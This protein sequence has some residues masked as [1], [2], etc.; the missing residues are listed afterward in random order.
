MIYR[1][2]ITKQAQEDIANHKKSGNKILLKRIA[3]LLNEL[4]VHPFKGT[5]NPEPL[6]Y[7]IQVYGLE[8]SIKNIA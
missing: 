3:V 2:E 6:K 5:G 7:Q 4:T 1:L 8:E